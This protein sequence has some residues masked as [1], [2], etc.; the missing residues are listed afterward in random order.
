M[1]CSRAVQRAPQA[2][3]GLIEAKYDCTRASVRGLHKFRG[4]RSGIRDTRHRVGGACA[5][6]D[7]GEQR[8]KPCQTP[9]RLYFDVGARFYGYSTDEGLKDK[10][11]VPTQWSGSRGS[12][13]IRLDLCVY[14]ASLRP[15]GPGG[16]NTFFIEGQLTVG[17]LAFELNTHV[18]VHK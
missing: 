17:R 14:I 1:M 7:Q 8:R 11:S 4:A 10:I 3:N 6:W 5:S 9:T 16:T 15:Q 13:Y 12:V 18:N 2:Q